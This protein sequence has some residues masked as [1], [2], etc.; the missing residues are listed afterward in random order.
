[1]NILLVLNL[2]ASVVRPLSVMNCVNVHQT[3]TRIVEEANSGKYD[4]CI[5][6]NDEHKISDPEFKYFPPH[7]LADSGDTGHLSAIEQKMKIPIHYT[8]KREFSAIFSST[9]EIAIAQYRPE[10][11]TVVGFTC[12]LDIVPTI[13]ALIDSGYNVKIIE[14]CCGDLTEDR[15][16]KAIEYLTFMGVP[17][18]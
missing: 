18:E 17:I 4:I 7:S 5:I 16:K 9:N 1:M 11:V 8:K 10:I 2:S 13:F 15:K 6:C 14:K 12:S 3:I